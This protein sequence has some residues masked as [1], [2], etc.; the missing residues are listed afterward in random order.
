M[1]YTAHDTPRTARDD[2]A[3][4]HVDAFVDALAALPFEQWIGVG[5]ALNDPWTERPTRSTAWAILQAILAQ[6][7]QLVPAWYVRDAV[8]TAV[9]LGTNAA[10]RS[11]TARLLVAAAHGAAEEAALALMAGA[12]LPRADFTVLY[13]PFAALIP[14]P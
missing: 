2:L 8:D 13:A 14:P 5:R 1:T 12:A 7:G 3:M 6:Q 11:R 10:C 9:F 4:E